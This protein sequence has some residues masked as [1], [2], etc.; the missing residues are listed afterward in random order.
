[1]AENEITGTA[2]NVGGKVESAVGSLT[3]DTKTQARG[4]ADQVAGKAEETYGEVKNTVSSAAES[5]ASTLGDMAQRVGSQ[6]SDLGGQAYAQGAQAAQYVGR[7]IKDE[8][9]I[10]ML[11]AGALG[12][13]IGYL[14]GRPSH[15]RSIEVG[16]FRASYRDR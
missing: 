2:R 5:T 1:M 7:Q 3:G 16:R 12:I 10:A 4:K 11:A 15:D 8:P 6:A 9:V 13:A 14:I